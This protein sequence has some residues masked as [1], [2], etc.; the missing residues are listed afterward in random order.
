MKCMLE[1]S[2]DVMAVENEGDRDRLGQRIGSDVFPRAS[3]SVFCYRNGMFCREQRDAICER[4]FD[5][6]VNGKPLVSLLCSSN[7]LE[8]LAYG[9]LYSEGVIGSL[10][11]VASCSLDTRE[12][13][14]SFRLAG[15]FDVPGVAVLS[16]GFGGKTLNCPVLSLERCCN[17]FRREGLRPGVLNDSLH[18]VEEVTA[19]MKTMRSFAREYAATRGIHCSALFREGKLLACFEDIGRHNTLDKLAGHCLLSGCGAQGAL[20]TTT[21]RISGEMFSKALRLGVRC[22]ASLLGPTDVAIA[23]AHD[24]GM[25]LMGY[26]AGSSATIY[27]GLDT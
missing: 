15:P 4:A 19:A 8:E 21:G 22:V 23:S 6:M 14:A 2:A 11:D 10:A 1:N 18:I 13:T 9:F 16:S 5:I 17:S 26:V 7:A 3:A 24:S 25:L 27:A 12:M 20:L